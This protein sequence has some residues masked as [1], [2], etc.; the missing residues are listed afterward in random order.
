AWVDG[1]AQQGDAAHPAP[2][3]P[4]ADALGPPTAVYDSGLDYTSSYTGSDEYRCFVIDPGMTSSF[5]L[6]AAGVHS[7]NNAIVHHT[8]VYAALPAYAAQV[9]QLDAADPRPGYECFGGPAFNAI[10]VAAAAVGSL[11]KA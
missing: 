6:I 8:I 9:D 1:G 4:A 7:T 3:V 2:I 10:P 11:P 5:N